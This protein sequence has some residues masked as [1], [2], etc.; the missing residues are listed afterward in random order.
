MGVRGGWNAKLGSGT[1]APG[2]RALGRSR[3]RRPGSRAPNDR[4]CPASRAAPPEA[5]RAPQPPPRGRAARKVPGFWFWFKLVASEMNFI[6]ATNTFSASV[7]FY[8]FKENLGIENNP[9]R[10]KFWWI[11]KIW[12]LCVVRAEKNYSFYRARLRY[13]YS[14]NNPIIYWMP[15]INMNVHSSRT[16]RTSNDWCRGTN[17]QNWTL[18]LFNTG[19]KTV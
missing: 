3:S 5:L 9:M 18:E 16:I 19:I 15:S 12:A 1:E 2:A 10:K 8:W 13:Y 4:P 11:K 7:T 17:V 6:C 14:Y